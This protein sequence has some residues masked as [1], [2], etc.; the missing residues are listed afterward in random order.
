MIVVEVAGESAAEV[1]FAPDKN[2]IQALAPDGIDQTCGERILPGSGVPC[3][4]RRCGCPSLAAEI[5][6]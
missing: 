4:L 3:G 6:G 2:V 1:S 5:L